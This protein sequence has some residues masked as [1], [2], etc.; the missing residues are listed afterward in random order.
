MNMGAIIFPW[1]KILCQTIFICEFD[2]KWENIFGDSTKVA[3]NGRQIQFFFDREK[4]F[5]HKMK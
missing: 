5:G 4:M 2:G 3:G 1:R